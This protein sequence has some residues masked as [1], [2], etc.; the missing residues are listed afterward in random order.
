MVVATD[1]RFNPDVCVKAGALKAIGLEVETP[2]KR[3]VARSLRV[4]RPALQSWPTSLSL[5]W[6]PSIRPRPG[7]SVQI[8]GAGS[9]S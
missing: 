8:E 3:G 5:S 7:R 2:D 4:G 1:T 9:R 6:Q